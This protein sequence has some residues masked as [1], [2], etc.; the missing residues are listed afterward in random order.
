MIS[1]FIHRPLFTAIIIFLL[2]GSIFACP[3]SAY[4]HY[5]DLGLEEAVRIAEQDLFE[6]KEKLNRSKQGLQTQQEN[7]EK[8]RAKE[9]NL[10]K[11]LAALNTK[12]IAQSKDLVSLYN[13]LQVE[14][15]KTQEMKEAL[16]QIQGEKK[17]LAEKTEKRLAAY[18]RM[19]DIGVLNITF[20][21]ATLPDLVNF[22]EYYR[23]M[24]RH[25][26]DLIKQFRTKLIEVEESRKTHE[27]QQV[28]IQEA[29]KQTTE[30]QQI[31]AQSKIEQRELLSRLKIEKNLYKQASQALEES[32]KTLFSE[33]QEL[34][35]QAQIAQQNKEEWMIST[36]PLEPHK[37]RKPAW[38]R[39]FGGQKGLL[40]PPV[41][42]T[43]TTLFGE[44]AASKAGTAPPS[45]GI[46]FSI[47]PGAIAR[48]IFKGK[49]VH[50]GFVKGYGQLIIISHTDNYYTMTSGIASFLVK[51][52]D[53]INQGDEIGMVSVHTGQL[54]G[55]IHLEIRL[56]TEAL[57]PLSWLDPQTLIISPGLQTQH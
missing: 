48:A 10:F 53:I 56:K 14:K 15:I 27:M 37:K 19:G 1:R 9:E 11:E 5:D 41:K 24:L 40:P 33:L 38:M 20:S 50:T 3:V 55:S 46:D 35:K 8:T 39:G 51:A 16:E 23:Y 49:V 4:E 13:Q 18:Y 26:Q 29:M 34:E 31:L 21:S 42:G 45:Y 52:G 2:Q 47:P 12:I 30:Q 36:F 17:I 22:H 44:T 57:D 54:Q 43:V 6:H 28:K 7:F 32:T 25:D